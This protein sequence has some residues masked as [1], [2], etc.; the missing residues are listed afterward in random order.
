[1]AVAMIPFLLLANDAS[2]QQPTIG[3][4]L[5]NGQMQIQTQTGQQPAAGSFVPQ[6][7]QMPPS[8][9]RQGWSTNPNAIGPQFNSAVVPFVKTELSENSKVETNGDRVTLVVRGEELSAVLITIAEDMGLNVVTAAEVTGNVSVTLNDVPLDDALDAILHVHGFRW[10]RMAGK[11]T[12]GQRQSARDIILVSKMQKTESPLSPN[13]DGRE[14][15]VFHLDF[16]SAVDV[17]KTVRGLLS[18]IGNAFVTEVDSSDRR[19]HREELLVE[20]V[21]EYLRRIEAYV[22]QADQPPAQVLIE[23]H[24]LQVNLRD[25]NRHGVDIQ[26]VASMAN[27]EIT[28]Q[29][30]GIANLASNPAFLLNVDG[31]RVDSIIEV[32]QGTTDAKTLASPKVLAVNGQEARIQIGESLGYLTTTT[33]QTAS[34]QTANFLDLGVVL[35]VTPQI[36]RDGRILMNVKP[37]VSSGRINTVTGLPD[38]ETTEV[39]STVLLPNGHAMVIGGLIKEEN[40]DQQS[41]LP[42]AGDIPV[43]GKLFQRRNRVKSRN[44]IIIV[45]LPRIVPYGELDQARH[46]EEIQRATSPLLDKPL[47]PVDRTRF[48]PLLPNANQYCEQTGRSMHCFPTPPVAYSPYNDAYYGTG[49]SYEQIPVL[50]GSGSVAPMPVP[51]EQQLVPVLPSSETQPAELIEAPAIQ[52]TSAEFPVPRQRNSGWQKARSRR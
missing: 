3:T 9:F 16:V 41:K 33:T 20:D 6:A 38:S 26:N 5:Q 19:K 10:V 12:R 37:E 43:L 25:D 4:P 8:A 28:L 34:V 27:A 1:M 48:E 50:P 40:T 47:N 44:E 52:Q 29:N 23:A 31:R 18:P 2:A 32:L 7:S 15:R 14:L 24:V 46:A 49:Q 35:S 21:P 51:T 42:I 13:V 17:E 39:E 30:N 22:A 11:Q 36:S 45:L